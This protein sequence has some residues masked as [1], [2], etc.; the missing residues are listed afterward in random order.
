MPYSLHPVFRNVSYRPCSFPRRAWC[1]WHSI[2]QAV[3]FPHRKDI[4]YQAVPSC[5]LYKLPSPFTWASKPSRIPSLIRLPKSPSDDSYLKSPSTLSRDYSSHNV[6][7][8]TS[9]AIPY[10]S[11]VSE[12]HNDNN[13]PFPNLKSP[14]M[15]YVPYQHLYNTCRITFTLHRLYELN[16]FREVEGMVEMLLLGKMAAHTPF[17]GTNR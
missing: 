13:F 5:Q 15:S 14:V 4:Q 2:F 10:Q 16:S 7:L 17:V 12:T 3:W 1:L 11:V 9:C 8:L 6:T